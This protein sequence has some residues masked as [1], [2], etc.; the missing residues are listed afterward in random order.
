VLLSAVPD[1]ASAVPG[2]HGT[3]GHVYV[4]G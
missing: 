1:S 2:R 4:L 3:F